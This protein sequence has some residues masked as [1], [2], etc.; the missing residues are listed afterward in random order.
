M[1]FSGTAKFDQDKWDGNNQ[2]KQNIDPRVL[3]ECN[4]TNIMTA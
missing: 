3:S 2:C 1:L 4:R